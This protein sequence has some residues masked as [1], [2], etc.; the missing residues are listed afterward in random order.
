[1]DGRSRAVTWLIAAIVAGFLVYLLR[2]VLLPFVAGFAVAYILDP[3]VARLTRLRLGRGAASAIAIALFFLIAIGLLLMTLPIVQAQITTFAQRLPSYIERLRTVIEPAFE[4]FR[5]QVGSQDMGDLSKLVGSYAAQA[6]GWLGALLAGVLSG[7]AAIANAISLLFITPIVAFYLLRDWHKVMAKIDLWLPRTEAASIRARLREI[8]KT[9]DGFAR[10]QAL[11]CIILALFYAVGLTLARLDFSILV[12]VFAGLASFIPFLG[13]LGGGALAIGLA[14]IQ[15][16]TWGPVIAV[17]GIFVLGQVI[18][19]YLLTPRL[20]GDRVGL[21]PVWI[22][23]ALMAGGA[24]F[25]FLGLLLAV[26]MAA[27]IGV[28]ARYAAERYLASGFYH[29]REG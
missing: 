22:I 13:A 4:A 15:F 19:G 16:P 21:H 20:V 17:A 8:D 5:D 9:L 6:I 23:F 10:G 2:D 14:L 24:L 25:G 18:E 7:G 12:G 3:V 29:G 11:V 1:M 27:A 28:L 26:P